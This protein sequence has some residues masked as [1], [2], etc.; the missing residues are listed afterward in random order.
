[1]DKQ[2]TCNTRL[3]T[4]QVLSY[5]GMEENFPTVNYNLCLFL[6]KNINIFLQNNICNLHEHEILVRCMVQKT[7]QFH[8]NILSK[9]LIILDKIFFDF[10][11]IFFY[12]RLYIW[13]LVIFVIS[14]KWEDEIKSAAIKSN[15]LFERQYLF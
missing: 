6:L 7:R 2:R 15:L 11:F 1:M 8:T 14:H 3:I 10:L 9:I 12:C 5:G 4:V 13:E